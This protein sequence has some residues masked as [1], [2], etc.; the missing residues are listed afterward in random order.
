MGHKEPI[1]TSFESSSYE[2]LLFVRVSLHLQQRIT[3]QQVE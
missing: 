1:A 2:L 3:D